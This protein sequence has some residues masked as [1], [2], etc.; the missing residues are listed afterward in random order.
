MHKVFIKGVLFNEQETNILIED[1]HIIGIGKE[2]S[3]PMNA[4]IIEGKDKALFP[5]FANSHTHAAMTLFRGYGDD[6]PLGEWLTRYIFPREKELTAEMVYW[7]T[8][9]ACLEMIKSGTACMNDMY[10]FTPE[11]IKAVKDSGIRATIGYSVADNFDNELAEAAKRVYRQLEPMMIDDVDGRIHY[12]VAPHSIYATSGETLQWLADFAKEHQLRYHIHMSETTKEINDC[13]ERYG[14]RPFEY[15]ERLGVLYKM[16]DKF[17]GA[18]CLWVNDDEIQLM[19]KYHINVAH[20]PN[21]NLK[22]ASG[23]QFKYTELNDAG[24]N[25][26]L[27]TDGCSSSNNLDMIE[28][29]KVMSLLQKGWRQI[30]TIAPAKETLKVA[31]VNGYKAMGFNGGEIKVGSLADMMLIDLNNIA[32]VPNNNT[33]SN[34]IYASH[35]DCVDTLICN[36]EVLMEHRV[37]KDEK[38]IIERLKRLI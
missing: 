32:F 37:V 35:G 1:K 21:S 5:T 30:S 13:L 14:C 25:V 18:H 31:T 27:G 6:V 17:I 19:G 12:S 29:C 33:L 38:E 22:L 36:G 28:A 9:L 7:A 16:Q 10:F 11:V 24:I 15:L 4:Y 34:L 3:M 26:C 20:N 23:C 2:L 8:R